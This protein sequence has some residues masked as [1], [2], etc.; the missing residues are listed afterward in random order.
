MNKLSL[1]V[2]ITGILSLA[3]FA[4]KP[5]QAWAQSVNNTPPK[6]VKLED[7]G[8]FKITGDGNPF[9]PTNLKESN[10]PSDTTSRGIIGSDD[11]LPMISRTYPWSTVGKIVGIE[12]DSNSE[13]TCTGT[14]ISE[15][16]VLTNSHCV[17]SPESHHLSQKIYFLPNVIN[18]EYDKTDVAEGIKVVYGTDFTQSF[19][20]SQV[21]DWALIKL[22][23]P[24]GLKYGYLGWKSLPPSTLIANKDKFIFVGYSG[25]FPNPEKEGYQEFT[26]GPGWTASYQYGCSITSEKQGTLYHDCDTTGGSSGG[27]IIGIINGQPYIV[28]LNDAE[29]RDSD[30]KGVINLGVEIA[31]L[32]KFK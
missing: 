8:N 9:K 29:I 27:S 13:Y 30:G 17:I 20:D 3:I 1:T 2:F 15:D 22:N 7:A 12:A 19:H 31:F 24:V 26:A 21:N 4:N 5:L 32:N 28:A 11:R 6:F 10:K 25:D 18:R 16:I 23:K 14:L